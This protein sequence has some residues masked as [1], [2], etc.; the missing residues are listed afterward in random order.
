VPSVAAVEDNPGAVVTVFLVDDHEIVR[1]GL[2]TLLESHADVVVVGEA[3]T[4]AQAL[5]R[6][7]TAGADVAIL[8]VNLPDGS[9]IEVCRELRDSLPSTACLMLTSYADDEALLESVLAGAA[10][11]I[12][13]QVRGTDIVD[14]VRRAAAGKPLLDPAHRERAIARLQATDGVDPR[15]AELTA[16]ERRVLDLLA[17]G[18]TNRDIGQELHLAEKTVKNYVSNLLMKLGMGRRTEAAV[19]AVKAAARREARGIEP[20]PDI[21]PIRY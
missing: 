12:L 4:A 6:I 18:L 20:P 19:Y 8:D 21:D 14:C 11:F 15:L 17:E 9:G 5:T 7:P 10:G 1:E 2:R 13:K 16:Q 3:G